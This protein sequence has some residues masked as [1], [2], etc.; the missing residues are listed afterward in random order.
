MLG[1]WRADGLPEHP[2]RSRI[3]EATRQHDIGWQVEDAAPRLDPASGQPF[4]FIHMPEPVKQAVWPRAVD[5]LR[6]SPY[7]A[8]LVAQHAL[9]IYRRYDGQASFAAFFRTM[10]DARDEL[11]GACTEALP[12]AP[13]EGF[14]QAYAWLSIADL[15][16]LVA[17]HGWT[18][19]FDA[20]HYRIVLE[21]TALRVSPDPFGGATHTWRVPGRRLDARRYA[22][23]ADLRE[24]YAAAPVVWTTGTVCG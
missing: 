13:L 5:A 21:G 24:A 19:R 14:M 8:A 7:E 23:D 2:L 15:L 17:C 3:L 12:G 22:S 16:S 18:E 10:A 20:D 1:H 11:F 6:A 9:T 4:D